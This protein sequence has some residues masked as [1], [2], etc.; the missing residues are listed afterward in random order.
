MYVGAKGAEH[1]SAAFKTS[2]IYQNLEKRC[3]DPNAKIHNNKFNIP[4]Y[5]IGDSA[6][7]L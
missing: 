7:S 4:F 1:D 5:L 3:L 2:L 6:Y